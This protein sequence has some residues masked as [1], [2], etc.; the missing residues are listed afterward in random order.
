MKSLLSFL[1]VF[2]LLCASAP[3]R[4]WTSS[5]GKTIEAELKEV[6]TEEVILMMGRKEFTLPISRLSEQDQAYLQTVIEEKLTVGWRLF[7]QK[8]EQGKANLI[9]VELSPETQKALSANKLPPTRIKLEIH[10]PKDFDPSKAQKVFWPAGGINNEKERLAGN[11]RRLARMA[12]QALEAGYIVIAADTEHG[13]P[14]ETT[15]AVQTGDAAFHQEVIDRI[16]A[17]W[18]EFKNWM[19]AT[20]GNSSGA[21]ASFFRVAHLLAA[22][23]NV[24]GV[25]LGGCNQSMASAAAEEA[26][27]R[28]R[29]FRQV[30]VWFSTGD[31][32]KLVNASSKER[33]LSEIKDAG[34]KEIRNEGFEGGH[35]MNEE[36]LAKALAWFAEAPAG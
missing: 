9:E 29:E 14:R 2:I 30:R 23:A 10:L 28:G 11:F 12:G 31:E 21:K 27:I 24:K 3:A 22:E 36:E 34:F 6:T 15:I 7:G 20:G 8:L 33:V 17:E 18:P 19:H 32:D 25:F 1:P 13:N 35:G 26:G 16:T 4:E 5:D